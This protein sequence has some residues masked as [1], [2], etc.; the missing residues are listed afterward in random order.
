MKVSE[1]KGNI[2]N[3]MEAF[4]LEREEW[5]RT[6]LELPNGIPDS[7]TFRRLTVEKDHGR[8]ERRTYSLL[9]DLSGEKDCGKWAN[10]NGIGKAHKTSLALLKKAKYGRISKRG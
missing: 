10:L 3:D 6:F 8:L 5:L 7:D 9:T 2:T 4:G 1:L